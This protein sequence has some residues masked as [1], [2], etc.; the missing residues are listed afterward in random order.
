MLKKILSTVV[1]VISVLMIVFALI[2][3]LA[4]VMTKP[5]QAPSVFGYSMFRVLSGSMEPTIPTNSM[6][7]VKHTSP[8]QVEAGDVISFYSSDPELG[9]S[10]N[11]H[12]VVSVDKQNGVYVF[13]T[14]GDANLIVDKYTTSGA[15]L[16]GVVVFSSLFLGQTVRLLSNPIVFIPIIMIPLLALLLLNLV[17]TVRLAKQAAKEEEEKQAAYIR[18]ELARRKAQREAEAANHT[19][20]TDGSQDG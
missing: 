19:E 6:I 18:E 5:G 20:Q 15:D 4:V 10:V 12:R 11:T 17:K 7:L 16:I 14:K 3:I 9:G 13:E 1:T 8:S 2:F